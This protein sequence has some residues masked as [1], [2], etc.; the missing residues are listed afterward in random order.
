MGIA[1]GAPVCQFKK[2]IFK[3]SQE[4]SNI[5]YRESLIGSFED[6]IIH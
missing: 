6:E 4:V 1:A 3:K 5:T 2:F